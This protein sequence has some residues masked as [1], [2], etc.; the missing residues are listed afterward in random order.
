MKKTFIVFTAALAFTSRALYAIDLNSS[1]SSKSSVD[2][3]QNNFY[4]NISLDVGKQDYSAPSNKNAAEALIKLKMP[5]L[6]KDPLLNLFVDN[7]TY[8]GDA[9]T[10]GQM[11][12]EDIT[13]IIEGGK[14][15]SPVY[16]SGTQSLCTTNTINMTNISRMLVRHQ[17]PYTA[18]EPLETVPSRSY[19]GIIIDARGSIPVHGEYVSSAVY[20]CFFP[21][22]WDENM[23]RIYEKNMID[24][25]VA[26][27]RGI[28]RY[29]YSEDDR[30]YEDVTGTDPLYIK[31]YKVYGRNRT[32][33][34]LRRRDALKILTVPENLALL[35][36][37]KVTILLDKAN[38]IS[39]VGAPEKDDSYYAAFR[40]IKQYIYKNKVPDI[41]VEDTVPGLL[42]SVDLKFVPDSSELLPEDRV[43][44]AQIAEM[45]SA[46]LKEN[47]FTI[48]IEGHT[49][50]IGRPTGQ[51]N[52]SIERTR[53]VMNAL[54]SEGLPRELFTYKG[55]GATRPIADNKTEEGRRQ[56]RR[57][58]ITARPRSK[59]IQR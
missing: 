11:T 12:L 25:D 55:Y 28:V 6:I 53:T 4:S 49:A 52:L 44:I 59:F 33:P 2:W 34:I 42:F 1:F 9:V 57:V 39:D 5:S 15:N 29:N 58:D 19:T 38:L 32:D 35:K 54:V 36:Q 16:A 22:I 56:N 30:R 40:T 21:Q 46:I 31:A 41:G 7:E 23:N 3:T 47:E 50:D 20:P 37:G 10:G 43:R 45:L 14:R 27:T 51:M 17:Y 8:L 18:E 26:S 24:N 48:L 13:E